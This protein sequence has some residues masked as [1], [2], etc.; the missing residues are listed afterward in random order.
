MKFASILSVFLLFTPWAAARGGGKGGKG[1]EPSDND[2]FNGLSKLVHSDKCRLITSPSFGG[3]I[4]IIPVGPEILT[5]PLISCQLSGG[6][7]VTPYAVDAD[8]DESGVGF[9]SAIFGLGVF[10]C[11]S[12]EID[13]EE[14]QETCAPFTLGDTDNCDGSGGL[15]AFMFDL[16]GES[17]P[18]G[19]CCPL[20]T[21]ITEF[22]F[23]L[24]P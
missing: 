23:D 16:G 14:L 15:T 6:T 21:G 7:I 2:G 19:Y 5:V 18:G 22:F 3:A 20:V 24:S 11:P 12:C 10:C 17:A 1:C 8:G 13:F 9:F 4:P